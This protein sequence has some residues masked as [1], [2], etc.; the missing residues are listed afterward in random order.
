MIIDM[1]RA[2]QAVAALQ[3]LVK[4]TGQRGQ[5][6][7]LRR[8]HRPQLH[9]A[10]RIGGDHGVRPG[11][12]KRGAFLSRQGGGELRRGEM[13]TACATA[14]EVP[15]FRF[16]ES[17]PRPLQE[18]PRLQDD[19]LR[20][21]EVAGILEHDPFGRQLERQRFRRI[22]KGFR[23]IANARTQLSGLGNLIVRS[24]RGQIAQVRAAAGRRSDKNPRFL[25]QCVQGF[26]SQ[27]PGQ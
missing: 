16:D 4:K 6:W 9:P 19:A 15:I 22:E 10:S 14:A 12:E 5:T 13:I 18:P 2:W 25:A 17:R 23:E 27:L 20:V 3:T 1:T 21:P 7:S 24:H 8:P 11:G 26:S